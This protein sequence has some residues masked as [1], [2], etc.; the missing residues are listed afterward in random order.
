[1]DDM[2]Y[3]VKGVLVGFIGIFGLVCNIIA[4]HILKKQKVK[5]VND[6]ILL[7]KTLIIFAL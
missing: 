6:I 3:I 7:G 5:S 1:M 4:I 2:E